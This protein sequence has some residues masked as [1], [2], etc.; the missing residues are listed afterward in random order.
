MKYFL[1]KTEPSEYSI[2]D[3]KR[4]GTTSWS[5]VTNFL[6]VRYLKAMQ[7]GDIVLIYHSGKDKHIAGLA[8]VFGNSRPDPN[9]PKSWLVDFRFVRQFDT[10]VSLKDIKESHLFDDLK[11]VR[12]GR[13]STMEIPRELVE[14]L[15]ENGLEI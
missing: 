7:P 3:L 5:G 2:E 9:E 14:W 4:D 15:R 8:V 10:P 1:A 12:Q 11:L 6:A 13:L